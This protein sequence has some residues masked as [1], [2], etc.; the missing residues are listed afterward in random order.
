M[1]SSII[2]NILAT[3]AEDWKESAR[4]KIQPMIS[5]AILSHRFSKCSIAA[6]S[7]VLILFAG[8]NMIAQKSMDS[9]QELVEEKQFIIKMELP[10]EC[11]ASPIYEIVMI[12]QFL[13]Q[14][15]SALVAGML[16]A[17]IVTLVSWFCL[18]KSVFEN[19]SLWKSPI[20]FS[21]HFIH[22]L[23]LILLNANVI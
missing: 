11:N 23:F 10:S 8:S 17:L 20:L 1:L 6:Y 16:N 15:T 4:S 12:T 18:P 19:A 7:V 14:L 9:E 5:K 22:P 2:Y 13:L 3:M 21:H